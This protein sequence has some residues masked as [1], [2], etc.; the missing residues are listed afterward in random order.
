MKKE[1]ILACLLSAILPAGAK[2]EYGRAEFDHMLGDDGQRV[3]LRLPKV[4]KE[5]RGILYTH[6]NMTEEVLFRSP[7]FTSKMDTLG[8]A[9]VFVQSG[10]Q[11]WDVTKGCQ[12]RFEHII[13]TLA[14]V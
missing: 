12:E 10:S 5:V 13:D 14:D 9:M 1:L 6:Q 2:T 3:C 7:F 4:Q 11:N 8:V